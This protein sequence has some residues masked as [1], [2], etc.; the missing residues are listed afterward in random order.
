MSKRV[1]QRHCCVAEQTEIDACMNIG[2]VEG[3]VTEH[4]TRKIME[5][6]IADFPFTTSSAS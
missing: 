3:E 2:L 5:C 1:E 6:L 4:S